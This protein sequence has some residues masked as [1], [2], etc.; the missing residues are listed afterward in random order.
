MTVWRLIFVLI[1]FSSCG[2]EGKAPESTYADIKGYFHKESNRLS[3]S[4]AKVNKT[5]SRNGVSETKENIS[6]EW[7]TELSLF[8]ESDINKP[9]WSNSYNVSHENGDILYTANDSKLRTRSVRIA[10]NQQGRITKL[11]ILNSTKN[12]LYSS[13]EEL[14]Y[15]PDSL[16]QIIKKQDVLLI[17]NNS[18]KISGFFR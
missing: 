7:D 15:M 2:T 5:V 3:K 6:P 16:Y 4:K 17:G 10:K 11:Y 13:S 18:Y 8:A 14:L 1:L 9:A 12:Y